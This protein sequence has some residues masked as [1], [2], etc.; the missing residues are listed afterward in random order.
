M[1]APTIGHYIQSKSQGK[2]YSTLPPARCQWFT[3]Y[4]RK[5]LGMLKNTVSFLNNGVV[6]YVLFGA[7]QFILDFLLFVFLEKMGFYAVV[8]NITSRLVAATVGYQLN[9]KYTF[10][11]GKVKNY[12]MVTRY[13]VFWLSMTCVSSLLILVWNNFLTDLLPTSA[14][15]LIVECILSIV[16]Y[17]ISKI[18]V[19]KND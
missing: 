2:T 19:Y 10:G 9:K 4:V 16:G 13:W 15:K 18:W 1:S 3:A 5:E 6:K 17:L 11:V 12:A 8:A 14:G 7:F